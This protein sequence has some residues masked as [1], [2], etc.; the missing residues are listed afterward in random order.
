MFEAKIRTGNWDEG[1]IELVGMPK[2]FIL[3]YRILIVLEEDEYAELLKKADRNP[4]ST[5]NE[6]VK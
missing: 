2:D 5:V 3:S 4:Q 1:T 6:K